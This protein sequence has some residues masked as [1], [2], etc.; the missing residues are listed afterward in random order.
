M[1]IFVCLDYDNSIINRKI[2][3]WVVYIQP[4]GVMYL[5]NLFC[6]SDDAEVREKTA[7][8]M[9]KMTCD[10]LVGPRVR[11]ILL[12]ILPPALVDQM[13]DSPSTAVHMY[14]AQH[15]NPELIWTDESRERVSVVVV[16]LVEE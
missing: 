14:E 12:K 6:S 8:L 10:K 3:L 2:T 5:L 13:R 16:R 4:G 9:G 7:E 15:E 11:L 1:Q